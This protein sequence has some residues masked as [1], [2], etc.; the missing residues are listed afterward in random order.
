LQPREIEILKILADSPEPIGVLDLSV[1][2]HY[3]SNDRT[4]IHLQRLENW[5]LIHERRPYQRKS[6]QLTEKGK[7]KAAE[8]LAAD[9][10]GAIELRG[11]E[12]AQAA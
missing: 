12:Q 3:F 4:R 10:A 2:L 8:V 11:R 5:G 7:A 1:R 9:Q 6:V